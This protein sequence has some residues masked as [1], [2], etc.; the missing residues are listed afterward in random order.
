MKDSAY[1][2]QLLDD[3]RRCVRRRQ[4][5]VR[6]EETYLS[7]VRRFLRFAPG[8]VPDIQ[9]AARYIEYL[10]K[11]RRLSP[12]TQNLAASAVAFLFR[13]VL[14][15][16]DVTGIPRARS[17]HRRPHILTGPELKAVFAQLSGVKRYSSS[18]PAKGA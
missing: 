1:T 2:T 8:E 4:L 6:T 11:D 9:Q 7:W 12:S 16:E 3:V 13:E 10:T 15:Q 5:S 14:G 17:R 18:S